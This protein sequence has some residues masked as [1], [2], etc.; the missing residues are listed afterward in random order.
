MYNLCGVFVFSSTGFALNTKLK[1]C[2]R[3][4]IISVFSFILPTCAH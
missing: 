3:S 4:D 2:I 1:T